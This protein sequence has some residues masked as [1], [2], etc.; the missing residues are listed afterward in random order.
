MSQRS[1]HATAV[2]ALLRNAPPESNPLVTYDGQAADGAAGIY[3]VARF[4]TTRPDGTSIT[5]EQDQAN[6]RITLICAAG[7]VTSGSYAEDLRIVTARAEAALLGV[8]P[9]IAGRLCSPIR[10]DGDA[11]ADWDDSTGPSI[12]TQHIYYR[13]FSIPA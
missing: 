2:L 10:D 8:T 12:W 4:S 7:G 13:F 9:T 6:T 1:D 5:H 11:P 3:V